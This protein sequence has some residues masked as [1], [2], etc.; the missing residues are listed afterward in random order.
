MFSYDP[1]MFEIINVV[2][3]CEIEDIVIP[4]RE[5]IYQN[6]LYKRSGF[7]T[8]FLN[9]SFQWLEMMFRSLF[10]KHLIHHH[11]PVALKL[12]ISLPIKAEELFQPLD[13]RE[14]T[15]DHVKKEVGKQV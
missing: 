2:P 10:M 3:L 15:I 14:S 13:G 1:D 12:N 4:H 11:L 9:Q 7:V 5:E 6:I 8:E